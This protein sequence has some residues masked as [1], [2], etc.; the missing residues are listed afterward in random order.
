MRVTIDSKP[1]QFQPPN[2]GTSVRLLCQQLVAAGF[3]LS[4]SVGRAQKA[5]KV[6]R[7]VESKTKQLLNDRTVD[8]R[9]AMIRYLCAGRVELAPDGDSINGAG[10][11]GVGNGHAAGLSNLSEYGVLVHRG[12]SPIFVHLPPRDR[13]LGLYDLLDLLREQELRIHPDVQALLGNSRHNWVQHLDARFRRCTKP[14]VLLE[15]LQQILAPG[16]RIELPTIASLTDMSIKGGIN[17]IID[18]TPIVVPPIRSMRQV[19]ALCGILRHAGF[20]IKSSHGNP[21]FASSAGER[22]E[23]MIMLPQAVHPQGARRLVEWLV[24]AEEVLV[25]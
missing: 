2:N 24:E 17:L 6:P 10:H 11:N 4:S 5:G 18:G 8:G 12:S 9:L 15:I 21:P 7:D 14:E 3:S 25:A 23:V 1:F 22:R 20:R 13:S 19:L 16:Y